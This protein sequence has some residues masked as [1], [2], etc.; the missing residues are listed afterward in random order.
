MILT[1]I[2][3][4]V[5]LVGFVCLIIYSSI[6]ASKEIITGAA[7]WQSRAEAGHFEFRTHE[8]ALGDLDSSI[9]SGYWYSLLRKLTGTAPLTG[10]A[11][12]AL[13]FWVSGI[14]RLSD[15][16]MKDPMGVIQ[17]VFLGVFIGALLAIG[18]Q[19]V[20]LRVDFK[21]RKKTLE[22]S[23]A[24]DPK[25]LGSAYALLGPFMRDYVG[26]SE[27]L[28]QATGNMKELYTFLADTMKTVLTEFHLSMTDLNKA[29]Q[30]TSGH[31]EKSS[32]LHFDQ[33]KQNSIEFGQRIEDLSHVVEGTT[34]SVTQYLTE[35]AESTSTAKNILAEIVST[36]SVAISQTSAA[37]TKQVDSV[38]ELFAAELATMR[39]IGNQN[40]QNQARQF[41]E[42]YKRNQES[43]LALINTERKSIEIASKKLST[44]ADGLTSTSEPLVQLKNEI[45]SCIDTLRQQTAASTALNTALSAVSIALESTCSDTLRIQASMG[46]SLAQSSASFVQT[47]AGVETAI[48]QLIP[49]LQSTEGR[50]VS[51]THASEK[52]AANEEALTTKLDQSV[53]KIET[54]LQARKG[55]FG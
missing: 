7:S 5:F 49:V 54:A 22:V 14:T 10:V 40:V 4:L 30:R 15:D 13:L 55:W 21:A 18:N 8:E 26:L 28:K 1:W 48:K 42:E 52:L 32:K 11:V 35:T 36:A 39:D 2:I 43:F 23:S 25:K 45:H 44:A 9:H 16:G 53:Q 17:P 6:S 29:A 51:L 20:V 46:Q 27:Q 50:V 19:I 38:R 24:V 3:T 47:Q 37:I 33:I 12:T 31:L 34:E 41:L